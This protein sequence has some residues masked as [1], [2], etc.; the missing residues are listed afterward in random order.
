M[1]NIGLGALAAVTASSL[2]SVGLVLQGIEARRMPTDDSLRLSMITQLLRRPR[3]V[4]GGFVML[5]GFGFHVTALAI[6]P[7]TVVQP[8]LAAG[9]LVLLALGVRNQPEQL[10]K[11][12]LLGVAAIILGIVGLGVTAPEKSSSVAADGSL[13]VSFGALAAAALI[14]HALAAAN[15]SGAASSGL[16][17]T[18]SA[19]AGYALTGLTTKLLSDEL[20]DGDWL[21]ALFWL[22]ITAAAATLALVDQTSALQRRNVVEVGPL[23]YVIPVVVP[24]LLAPVLVGEAWSDAPAGA[25]PLLASL[26]VVCVGAAVLSKSA[27]VV[28]AAAESGAEQPSR[29]VPL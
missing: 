23:I 12:D 19:G 25:V 15:R 18:I 4:F 11:R 28:A 24:V 8:A 26:A 9:L 6:A 20:G 16:L 21:A 5:A 10:E 2:F 22:G 3:W 29:R 17:A 13:A 27:S 7:L 1:T 14:P